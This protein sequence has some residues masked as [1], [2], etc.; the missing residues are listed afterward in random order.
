MYQ[1]DYPVPEKDTFIY[2]QQLINDTDFLLEIPAEVEEYKDT[3]L[4]TKPVLQLK[5]TTFNLMLTA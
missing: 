5:N 2:F 1:T 4:I 3:T